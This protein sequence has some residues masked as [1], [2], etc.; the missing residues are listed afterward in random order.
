MIVWVSL[1][2]YVCEITTSI[3]I[4]LQTKYSYVAGKGKVGVLIIHLITRLTFNRI[5]DGETTCFQFL[6][7]AV[8]Y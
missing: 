7:L 4:T 8:H 1:N 6:F 5:Y 2:E 3:V